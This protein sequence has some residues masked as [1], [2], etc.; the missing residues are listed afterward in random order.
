[1]KSL[2]LYRGITVAES[3]VDFVIHDI[4]TNGLYQNEN[5]QWA[6]FIWKNVKRELDALYN[7]EDLTLNDTRPASVWIGKTTKKVYENWQEAPDS[8]NGGYREYIEGEHSICFADKLG[9]EY[10]ATQHNVFKEKSIPLLITLDLDLERLAIDGRDF[11]YTVLGFIDPKD[12]EK[13]K[14]QTEKLK[15]IF[16][17][18]IEKYIEKLVSHPNSEKTAIC[19][20]VICDDEII[21]EH[22]RNAEIIGGRHG[23]VFKSAFFGKT[24]ISREK[25]KNVEIIKE[26]IV[27]P[28]PTIT[29]NNILER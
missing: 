5:Q 20:L 4:K 25:I 24:P 18:K 26:H 28:Y 23:T 16:G 3:E 27:I 8:E 11:L 22:S 29:L 10:Y 15:K 12:F 21:L 2:K 9:A 7:K 14:R 13:T 1:M 6:G 19:D 17:K